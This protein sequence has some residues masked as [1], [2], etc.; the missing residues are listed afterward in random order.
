MIFQITDKPNLTEMWEEA[1]KKAFK[2][3]VFVEVIIRPERKLRS[4]GDKSQSHALNGFIQQICQ[5]TGNDFQD[6]KEY[7]KSR[8]VSMGYPMLMKNNKVVV[9][10]YGEPRGISEADSSVE[11]C[12]LLIEVACM[13][14]SEY[15]I[16]LRKE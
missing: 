16:E 10:P 15:G 7:I 11:E 4:T 1:C 14:A 5:E 6:V 12:A 13:L 2:R 9:N 8:A 3:N